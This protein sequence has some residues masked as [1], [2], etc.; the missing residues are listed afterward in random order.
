MMKAIIC[1]KY[2]PPEVLQIKE[3]DKPMPKEDEVLIKIHATA[4]TA[5]DLYIRGS[6]ILPLRYRILMRLF[7]GISKP[8]RSINGLV[9][10]GKIEAIGKQIKRFKVGDHVYG[11][12]GFD[13]GAYAEYKCMKEVDSTHGCISIMPNNI[14]F[15]EAT[16]ISYGGLLAFQY[17]EKGNVKKG[18]KVVIYGAS[19]TT[20]IIAIQYAKYMGAE[21]TAVC[22]T[23]NIEL[24]KSF[25]VDNV[26]DYTKQNLI[27]ES[28][29]FDF[30]LD[31]V[32][33]IK[34]SHLKVS[35]KKALTQG[36]KYSSIDDGDLKLDSKRLELIKELTES[37]HVKAF[38]DKCFEIED[39]VQAHTYVESGHKRGGVAIKL[40]NL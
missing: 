34:T 26:L 22:S 20:G 33:K 21:V 19:S 8:R 30:M 3:V 13:L 27:D 23:R 5:S 25:G 32:G 10:A 2:G 1:T 40:S 17:L 18:D 35:C 15:E 4:V 6:L 14:S 7:L 12:T 36:G 16:M 24:I 37:G 28:V 31:A 39:M 38:I 11:L 29:K 9:L